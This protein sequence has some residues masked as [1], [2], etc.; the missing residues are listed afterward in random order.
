MKRWMIWMVVVLLPVLCMHGAQTAKNNR[1]T[2]VLSCELHCQGCC[3][4]IMKNIAFEKGV[5]DI[6]CDLKTKTVT[7]TYDPTK[8]TLEQLL[9][10]FERIGKPAKVKV[11]S[12]ESRV[13][14]GESRVES[15]KKTNTF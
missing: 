15:E 8:T 11:E 13:E 1:E 6:V 2:V 10:A 4:K 12:G 5:K 9:K 3:E 7:V 14:R